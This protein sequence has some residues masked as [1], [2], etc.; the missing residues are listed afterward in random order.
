MQGAFTQKTF[1]TQIDIC[2]NKMCALLR[3]EKEKKDDIYFRSLEKKEKNG[4]FQVSPL[5][6]QSNTN[7][8]SWDHFENHWSLVSSPR[9]LLNGP[10]GSSKVN[11]CFLQRPWHFSMWRTPKKKNKCGYGGV[12]VDGVGLGALHWGV[13]PS[14]PS[15]RQK[16][17]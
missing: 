12:G 10:C 4:R 13:G 15:F 8:I 7:A 6:L 11:N 9:Y 1:T 16:G 14:R 3:G 2:K 17:K 5:F